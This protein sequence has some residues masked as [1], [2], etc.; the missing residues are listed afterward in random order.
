MSDAA[1]PIPPVT[2]PA[3]ATPGVG[4]KNA[5][6]LTLEDAD[7][8]IPAAPPGLAAE[9]LRPVT[10]DQVRSDTPAVVAYELGRLNARMASRVALTADLTRWERRRLERYEKFVRKEDGWLYRPAR[11]SILTGVTPETDWALRLLVAPGATGFGEVRGKIRE[12]YK[13]VERRAAA[14][15][16]QAE[17]IEEPEQSPWHEVACPPPWVV[18]EVGRYQAQLTAYE[19]V[20]TS[21][22]DSTE[23]L[24]GHVDILLGDAA[25]TDGPPPAAAYR[26]GLSVGR[27]ETPRDAWA[28]TGTPPPGT[29]ED[30]GADIDSPFALMRR[31]V[32]QAPDDLSVRA[33]LEGETGGPPAYVD[34]RLPA[35]PCELASEDGWFDE[36]LAACLTAGLAREALPSKPILQTRRNV[37]LPGWLTPAS[38]D[39][40]LTFL[41]E[42]DRT[43]LSTLADGERAENAENSTS[44]GAPAAKPGY[45]GLT[46]DQQ[47][48]KVWRQQES[49]EVSEDRKRDA[50]GL[51]A[52]TLAEFARSAATDGHLTVEHLHRVRRR[53]SGKENATKNAVEQM[54]AAARK[55]LRNQTGDSELEDDQR[56][57]RLEIP[58][59]EDSTYAIRVVEADGRSD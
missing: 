27:I 18:E 40:L 25:V 8:C 2:P 42:V 34:P 1:P 36:L 17:E 51:A 39:E 23:E 31:L 12:E 49:E 6:G 54:I 58:T 5:D 32:R 28:R 33:V 10:F 15:Q 13:A 29:A 47:A 4:E 11:P 26:L 53:H 3:A 14:M 45:L 44:A 56:L 7:G 22:L 41:R 20:V 57:D 59:A 48:K 16:H 9:Y 19:A 46:V 43:A 37:P 24:L 21:R 52:A 55:V 30:S 38:R 50:K 35:A